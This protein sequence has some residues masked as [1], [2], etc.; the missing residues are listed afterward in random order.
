MISGYS[1]T[2][3][4]LK[5]AQAMLDKL[6]LEYKDI[7]EICLKGFMKEL[8]ELEKQ[9]DALT[10]LLEDAASRKPDGALTEEEVKKLE[11]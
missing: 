8:D 10:Q 9:T 4:V 7:A 6:G 2:L 11:E 3:L 5:E 1:Y